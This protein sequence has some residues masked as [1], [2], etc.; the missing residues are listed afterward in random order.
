MTVFASWMLRRFWRSGLWMP[1]LLLPPIVFAGV[2]L[3]GDGAPEVP[4]AVLLGLQLHLL[5]V[6]AV[7]HVLTSVHRARWDLLL[8]R[9]VGFPGLL[10]GTWIGGALPLLACLAVSTGIATVVGLASERVRSRAIPG[11]DYYPQADIW[12]GLPAAAAPIP[13]DPTDRRKWLE[14]DAPWTIE[15]RG[16]RRGQEALRAEIRAEI[17]RFL[18]EN[19]RF[20]LYSSDRLEARVRFPD[21]EG[22]RDRA[23]PVEGLDLRDGRAVPFA[24]PAAAVRYDGSLLVSVERADEHPETRTALESGSAGAHEHARGRTVFWFDRRPGPNGHL[25]GGLFVVSER[26]GFAAN[27]ARASVQGAGL[28]VLLSA[29]TTLAA[30]LFSRPVAFAFLLTVFVCGSSMAFLR[31]VVDSLSIRSSIQIFGRLRQPTLFDSALKAMMEFWIAVLPDFGPLKGDGL[32]FH[33]LAIRWST[34][35]EAHAM[36]LGYTVLCLAAAAV[37]LRRWEPV[38]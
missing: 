27:F 10:L 23:P 29:L 20:V 30:F 25:R 17:G 2:L 32:V 14:S 13:A 9:R 36:V 8:T 21:P 12:R 3:S 28:V 1:A 16:V 37:C 4:Y 35:L 34:I 38:R 26:I 18:E 33:G 11:R 15:I 5:P 6:L 19:G 7:V 22:G 24:I 31:E